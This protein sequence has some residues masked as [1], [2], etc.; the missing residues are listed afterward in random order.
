MLAVE[1]RDIA[2][3]ANFSAL[4]GFSELR[5]DIA[6]FVLEIVEFHLHE[7]V[8][9][10]RLIR[11]LDDGVGKAL[12]ANVDDGVEV[13]GETSEPLTL[14]AGEWVHGILTVTFA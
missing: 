12:L 7:L 4:G 6:L 3:N 10:Q 14:T 5:R 1:R 9:A 2:E 13:M 11:G 8:I